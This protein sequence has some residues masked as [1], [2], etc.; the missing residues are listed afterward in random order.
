[1]EVAMNQREMQNAEWKEIWKDEY[2]NGYV[3]CQIIMEGKYILVS[4]MREKS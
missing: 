2:L 4:M 3:V 1:M